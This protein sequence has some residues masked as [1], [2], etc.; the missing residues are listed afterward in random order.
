MGKR[1]VDGFEVGQSSAK[2]VVVLCLEQS[3]LPETVSERKACPKRFQLELRKRQLVYELNVIQQD[4]TIRSAGRL[5]PL[6]SLTGL[7]PARTTQNGTHNRPYEALLRSI[8][9]LF[10]YYSVQM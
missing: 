9:V 8:S 7:F 5:S 1:S 3:E 4:Q 10:C 6:V 2:L